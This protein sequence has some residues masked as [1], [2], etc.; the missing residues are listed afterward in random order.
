MKALRD[1]TLPLISIPPV[2]RR[3]AIQANNCEL[4][5]ITLQMIQNIQF[6]GFL[7]EDLNTHISNFLELCDT[8]KYNRVSDNAILLRLFAFLLKDKAKYWLN[9]EPPSSITSW[10]NL[11]YKFLSKNFLPA[12]AAKMRIEILIMRGTDLQ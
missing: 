2:I 5:P 6:I 11:V 1:Y 4:K 8:V 3:L 9:S 12:K 7:N 10:D